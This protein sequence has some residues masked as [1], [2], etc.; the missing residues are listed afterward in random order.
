MVEIKIG[1]FNV[2][3]TEEDG[4]LIRD[5]ETGEVIEF[6]GPPLLEAI[7]DLWDAHC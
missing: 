3:L 5:T 2:S 4:I 6:N 1:K 7:E